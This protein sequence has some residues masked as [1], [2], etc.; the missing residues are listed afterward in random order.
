M[1]VLN[2][3]GQ[4][5]V[6]T[7]KQDG[8]NK[9]L[10]VH[11]KIVSSVFAN[12]ERKGYY[13]RDKT[14]YYIDCTSGS[15]FNQDV[16]ELG[17]PIVFI[18]RIQK[19]N[20]KYKAYFVDIEEGNI[21]SL[22]EKIYSP[23]CEFICADNNIAVPEII[24]ELPGKSYGLC[25]MDMNG[26]PNFG[27]IEKISLKMKKMD[28]LIR[29]PATAIK[30]DRCQNG[31]CRDSL[32]DSIKKIHKEKMIIREP[33]PDDSWQW[34]F[35]FLTNYTNVSDWKR[36]RFYDST[37]FEGQQ[38]LE[39]LNYSKKEIEDLNNSKNNHNNDA[40]KRSGGIC[41]I[42]K[43]SPAKEIHHIKG[44]YDLFKSEN[45]IHVCH[46][47]HCKLEGKDE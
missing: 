10:C 11:M 36:E 2:G 20:L 33:L 4:S 43:K 12:N 31:S 1:A 6:T 39:R 9:Y 25:Y 17:S 47:C 13:I 5:I 22:R 42:C 32:I 26:I 41:E 21:F 44:T 7:D 15:G 16:E 40:K 46:E 19:S 28:I 18:N 34:T 14:Y 3:M 45:R 24:Q 35:L 8:L 29:C 23:N 30:R 27:L 37:S 38:I